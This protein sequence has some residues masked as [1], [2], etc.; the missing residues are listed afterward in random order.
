MAL[1]EVTVILFT[2]NQEAFIE[3]TVR[4]II[5][6]THRPI[7]LILIDDA[8]SDSTVDK[9]RKLIDESAPDIKLQVI[10]KTR[11]CGIP[12]SFN[13]AR[14]LI[15]GEYAVMFGGDDLMHPNKLKEQREALERN[16]GASACYHEAEMF[17]SNSGKSLGL[18]TRGRRVGWKL[19]VMTNKA[20][21]RSELILPQ[22]LMYRTIVFG[23][24]CFDARL[25]WAGDLLFNMEVTQSG[26]IIPIQESFVKYRKHKNAITASDG[27]SSG[28]IEELMVFYAIAMCRFP[29]FA[30]EV[31]Y[32]ERRFLARNAR[33]MAGKSQGTQ[34]HKLILWGRYRLPG[35]S[36]F[37]FSLLYGKLIQIAKGLR[38]SLI[39]HNKDAES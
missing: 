35:L 2:F 24:T 39:M 18:Y 34:R 29:K 3:E 38:H 17:E 36:R 11:N 5:D 31:S 28:I 9:A 27:F 10:T 26:P 4:S 15:T 12:D 1:G 13:R 21:L 7:Q 32:E 14:E 6:Q 16:P 22:T 25:K 33:Q 19:P 23:T 20:F 8:S 30:R 37:F